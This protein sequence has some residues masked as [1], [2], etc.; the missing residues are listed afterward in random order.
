MAAVSKNISWSEREDYFADHLRSL[1]LKREQESLIEQNN[2]LSNSQESWWKRFRQFH[3]SEHEDIESIAKMVAGPE[4]KKVGSNIAKSTSAV[5]I[6][7]DGGEDSK[8]SSG[9]AEK[10]IGTMQQKPSLGG[11]ILSLL[12]QDMNSFSNIMI[13]ELID[14]SI[15]PVMALIAKVSVYIIPIL[16]IFILLMTAY[17][18]TS[19]LMRTVI[20]GAK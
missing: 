3:R 16:V 6:E 8:V 14:Y 4:V 12:G 1:R 2:A 10:A 5:A 19:E 9:A 13:R 11:F 15:L 17:G 7:Y 20:P 18:E